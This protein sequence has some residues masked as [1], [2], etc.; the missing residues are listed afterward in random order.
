MIDTGE[1]KK[2]PITEA[3]RVMGIELNKYNKSKCFMHHENNASLSFDI[4][5][6][7][8]HCFGC[9]TG[10]D[11]ITL[12]MKYLCLDYRS[13]IYYLAARFNISETIFPGKND[14]SSEETGKNGS[15]F[16]NPA[17]KNMNIEICRNIQNQ[18]ITPNDNT[19]NRENIKENNNTLRA[20][21]GK[22]MEVQECPE[23]RQINYEKNTEIYEC[24]QDQCI[25]LDKS[26]M[27]HDQSKEY[28][29]ARGLTEKILLKFG[30]FSIKNYLEIN[31]FLNEHYT[32]EE[33]SIAGITSE[34]G[35]LLFFKHNIIFPYY[36]NGRIICLRGRITGSDNNTSKYIGLKNI[37]SKIFYNYDIIS[38]MRP[39][40]EL[41]ICEGEIDC[42][43]LNMLGI[44]A[45]AIPGVTNIPPAEEWKKLSDY[46]INILFDSDDAGRKALIEIKKISDKLRLKITIIKLKNKDIN[47]LLNGI[48]P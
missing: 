30:V 12:A 44:K 41:Y 9:H 42:I 35:N 23:M 16:S 17:A 25:D 3:A 22:N 24:L 15:A 27:I 40:E 37:S 32:R 19:G 5:K 39:N 1:I 20:D 45:I 4:K 21:S 11:V 14:S 26:T 36:R 13:A 28:L 38:T 48:K 43:T 8:F 7:Y 2:I 47:E 33:L 6:N 10:G 46:R 29:I 18:C 34:K 31:K